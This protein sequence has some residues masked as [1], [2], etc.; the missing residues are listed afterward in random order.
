MGKETVDKIN[1]LIKQHH[2]FFSR[3]IPL[4]ASENITSKACRMATICDF[5]HR[6][7]E[8]WPGKRVYAGCEYLDQVEILCQDLAKQYWRSA[9]ADVRPISGVVANL[10]MYTAT[11][12]PCGKMMA[13]PIPSGGHI[14]HGPKIAKKTGNEIN[15]TAGAVRGLEVEYLA[16]DQAEMNLDVDESAKRIRDFQPE[17]LLFGGSVFLFPHPVKELSD[18][19]KEV[20]ARVA[21]DG[22]HVAGLIGSGYF[23]QPLEEG[24]EIFTLST[25]KTFPGPQHGCILT[26]GPDDLDEK[27]KN[28]CFP[29]MLS[30][31]HLHNVAGF[32]ITLAE[33]LEFG[34]EYHGQVIKNAKALAEALA[35]AGFKPLCEH[36]GYTE[37]HQ[38]MLDITGLQKSFGLGADIEK[39]LEK[40]GIIVN[41]NLLPWDAKE[42]RAYMNPGGVRLGTSEVTRLGMKE[43]DMEVIAGFFKKVIL[44]KKDPKKIAPEVAEFAQNFQ[45]VKFCFEETPAFEWY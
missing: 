41:R 31:H 12:S 19:A 36:K 9:F 35:A 22:A 6:Y 3:A 17:L 14:S 32:A 11:T 20:G 42:G 1:D 44:D 30:N 15:G 23:Q 13:M 28:A 16:F 33:M 10:A 5:Q 45:T 8:G 34:Q 38:V 24:A 4:I 40:A 29:S 25:H 37:S 7:A 26:N 27:I 39:G 43:S 21:Y 2:E 18:V